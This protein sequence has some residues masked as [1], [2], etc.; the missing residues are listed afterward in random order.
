MFGRICRLLAIAAVTFQLGACIGSDY[1]LK[2]SLTPEFPVKPGTYVKVDSPDTVISV[3]RLGDAYRIYNRSTKLT[4]YA[5]L[6]KIPEYEGY[7]LQY[8]DRRKRPIIYLFMKTT[9]KGFEIFYVENLA[10]TV[11][12][13]VAKLLVPITEED[14]KNNTINIANGRRDTLYVVREVARANLKLTVIESY[15]L[16]P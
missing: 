12:E 14:R 16:R 8:Y 4:T 9:D 11:P 7:V 6:Y 10:T 15:E 5:R 2:T 1:D 3:R 13:H